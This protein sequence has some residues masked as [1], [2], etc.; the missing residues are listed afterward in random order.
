MR[1]FEVGKTYYCRSV[2]DY[3]CVWKYTIASRTEKTIRTT[4]GK[5]LRINKKLTNYFDIEQVLP[6]GN[7][8]MAPI[9]S[10]D[11]VI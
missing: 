7:Y 8:S 3:D 2:C 4:C 6:L 9:L 5:T 11:K 1:K 10:A